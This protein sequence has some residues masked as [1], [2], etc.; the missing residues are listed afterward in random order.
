MKDDPLKKESLSPDMQSRL[1]SFN[2]GDT[3][4]FNS[5][6]MER[7]SNSID[8]TPNL[9]HS[10]FSQLFT[11]HTAVQED[12]DRVHPNQ[13]FGE[14]NQDQPNNDLFHKAFYSERYRKKEEMFLLNER[15]PQLA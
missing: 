15:F 8:T 14:L 9:H 7:L 3:L 13:S 10:T 2:L 11:V 4:S 1:D 12:Q 6:Y 5:I